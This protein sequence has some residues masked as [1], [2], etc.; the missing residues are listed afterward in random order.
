MNAIITEIVTFFLSKIFDWLMERA[1][2]DPKYFKILLLF[3]ALQIT[4]K[5]GRGLEFAC[6]LVW[7]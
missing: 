4:T 2:K 5:Q 6:C 1:S 7:L 3:P